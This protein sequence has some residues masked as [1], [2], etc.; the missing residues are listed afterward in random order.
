MTTVE[1][2][3]ERFVRKIQSAVGVEV[4]I[5]EEG[6]LV[7]QVSPLQVV[8]ALTILQ[9]RQ[10]LRFV[11]L[12]DMVVVDR[13]ASDERFEVNYI[14]TSLLLK[15]RLCVQTFVEEYEVMESVAAVYPSAVWFE[16]ENQEIFGLSFRV[17]PALEPLWGTATQRPCLRKRS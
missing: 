13:P 8:R 9:G 15:M 2:I 10:D 11:L 5:T 4:E 16:R 17:F 6:E 1:E 7:L 12:T 14:L 3:S